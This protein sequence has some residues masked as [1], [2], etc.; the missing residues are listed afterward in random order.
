[1]G[2]TKSP[3]VF[4]L[5]FF[6]SLSFQRTAIL[7]THDLVTETLEITVEL[8]ITSQITNLIM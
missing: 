1:M 2:C 5:F 4:L 8:E 7:E 3:E 6:L